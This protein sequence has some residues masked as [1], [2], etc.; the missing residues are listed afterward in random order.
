MKEMG[1]ETLDPI[2]QQVIAIV[3]RV[4]HVP[5]ERIKPTTNLRTELNVDSL[6]GLQIV[7]DVE[8]AWNVRVPDDQ[9]DF[10]TSID[11]IVAKVRELSATPAA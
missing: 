2:Q 3:S 11:T 7:A 10:Y 5:E 4:T 1:A 8:T 9:V 6:Q